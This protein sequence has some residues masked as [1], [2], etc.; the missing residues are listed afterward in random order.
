MVFVTSE[1]GIESVNQTKAVQI[2]QPN[3]ENEGGRGVLVHDGASSEEKK[4]YTRKKYT[5]YMVIP[6]Y[7]RIN[8]QETPHKGKT[9]PIN[10]YKF[11]LESF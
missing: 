3:D 9:P 6:P 10:V 1:A 7:S 8:F 4:C 2:R 5:A 11:K